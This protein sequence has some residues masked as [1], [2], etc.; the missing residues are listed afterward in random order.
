MEKPSQQR[1]DRSTVIEEVLMR[2]ARV[3]EFGDLAGVTI[4]EVPDPI[5]AADQILIRVTA[6]AL[7][8]LDYKV[9]LT[10]H[11]GVRELPLTLGFDAVGTVEA[12]GPEVKSVAVGDRVCAMADIMTP[13]TA[14]DLVVVR[15]HNVAKVPA[16]VADNEA[17]GLP[18]AALTA[19]QAW[20]TAGLDK[21]QSV[22][23]HGG[24]GGVGH[25]AI[26]LAKLRGATVYATASA[27]HLD[28]LEDLGVDH[29]ID[30]HSTSPSKF[31]GLVDVVLDTRGGA[32][33]AASLQ[34]MRPGGTL[35]S[36]VG[37][38]PTPEEA[39]DEVTV[40]RMLVEPRAHELAS[41]VALVADVRLRVLVESVVPLERIVD[42]LQ[43]LYAGHTVGKRIL[44]V[45]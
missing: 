24:A 20:D 11:R 27:A 19:L 31:A 38:T 15:E 22:L 16:G 29:P 28:L 21:G 7:N 30:Y 36:I 40:V 10:G 5:P 41:L 8:P 32:V 4:E 42:A 17:A 12:I 45:S 14:A 6:A 37:F 13:G 35:V 43:A 3:R 18:L 39:R 44:K 34:G 1:L 9:A 25:F 26:Q 23:V 33:A 2:A